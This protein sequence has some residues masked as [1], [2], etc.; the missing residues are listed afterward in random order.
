MR[1]ENLFLSTAAVLLTLSCSAQTP[2][3]PEFRSILGRWVTQR[4]DLGPSASYEHHLTFSPFRRFA[5]EVRNYGSYPGQGPE[6]FSGYSRVEGTYNI[7]GN[8]LR[9]SPKRLVWWDLFYGKNSPTQTIEPYP[10]GSLFDDA[11]SEIVGDRLTLRYV[12]YPSDA[13][14]E[15][16]LELIRAFRE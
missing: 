15:T 4:F 10:Y 12:S 6:E 13:P 11:R 3:E 7:D 1:T 2:T 9:F 8:R 5:S 16:T 14:V